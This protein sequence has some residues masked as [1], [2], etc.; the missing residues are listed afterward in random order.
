MGTVGVE[1]R[2]I[3]VVAAFS[4]YPLEAVMFL[5]LEDDRVCRQIDAIICA[6][7]E[8]LQYLEG[9]PTAFWER[10]VQSMGL[11]V[12]PSRIRSDTLFAAH[13]G[14]AYFTRK[15][16]WQ[17]LRRPWSIVRGDI[18]A[19]F[20]KLLNE[21]ETTLDPTSA[22]IVSLLLSGFYNYKMNKQS[23]G[24]HTVSIVYN[25]FIYSE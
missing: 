15:C 21:D 22:S 20:E 5:L 23:R 24:P 19:Q 4:S 25:M 17:Y 3:S 16:V 2:C 6:M 12:Q 7:D 9:L 13:A 11:H 1:G 18:P 8:E 14:C 10:V